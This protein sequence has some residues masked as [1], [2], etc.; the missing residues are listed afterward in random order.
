MK[1]VA[2]KLMELSQDDRTT[3]A[4]ILLGYDVEGLGDH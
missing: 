3:L 2:A 4:A 1:S